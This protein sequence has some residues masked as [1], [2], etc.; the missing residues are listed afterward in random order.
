MKTGQTLVVSDWRYL[1][2]YAVA[3]QACDQYAVKL[4]TVLIRAPRVDRRKR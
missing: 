2:E 1:N 4:H 3:K